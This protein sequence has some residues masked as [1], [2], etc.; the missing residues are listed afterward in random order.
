[1]ICF[2]SANRDVSVGSYRIWV[3]DLSYYFSKIGV[4]S[5]IISDPNKIYKYDTVI[6]SKQHP[7]LAAQ[8]KKI[9]PR[10]KIGTINLAADQSS[11]P[12]DFVIVGSIE[13]RI[14]LSEHKNVFIFPLIEQAFQNSELKNHLLKKDDEKIKICFHGHNP[15]LNKFEYGLRQALESLDNKIELELHVITGDPN[16]NWQYGKPKIKNIKMKKWDITTIK[17]D[18]LECDIGLVPNI[19]DLITFNKDYNPK[20]KN[21]FGLHNT[22]YFFRF[23]NKSNAGRCFVFHQLGVPVIADLTPS[24]LHILGDPEC[25]YI[26]NNKQTWEAAMTDKNKRDLVSKKAKEEFDRLYD[27]L[28]WADRLHKKIIQ[29]GV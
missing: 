10:K 11:N 20:I 27:P 22:D 25:G 26:A 7:D 17:E 9:F 24:N 6:F 15:H 4:K 18:I 5:A 16:Y 8:A 3:E 14:S 1:M 12:C 23:K 28:D 19:T 2:F 21:N 29:L 13:E